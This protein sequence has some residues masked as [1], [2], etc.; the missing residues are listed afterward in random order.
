MRNNKGVFE[1]AKNVVENNT[2]KQFKESRL[3]VI[4]TIY[5]FVL[6]ILLN[7]VMN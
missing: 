6:I 1:K 5:P 7:R 4:L 2:G 3:G